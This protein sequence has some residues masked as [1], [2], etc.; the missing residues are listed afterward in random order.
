M[1]RFQGPKMSPFSGPTPSSGPRNGCCPHQNHF[2]PSHINNR[3]YIKVKPYADG[4]ILWRDKST[5]IVKVDSYRLKQSERVHKIIS[6]CVSIF[7]TVAWPPKFRVT[8]IGKKLKMLTVN[9]Y[10]GFS[11]CRVMFSEN[12]KSTH[13]KH[14]TS[15]TGNPKQNFCSTIF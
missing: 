6:K 15:S 9:L 1:W 12:Y 11:Y 10:S 2:V 13:Q 14:W 5:L 4:E 7:L 3:C 8:M